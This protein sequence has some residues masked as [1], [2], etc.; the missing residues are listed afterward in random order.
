MEVGDEL[1]GISLPELEMSDR[2]RAGKGQIG[3]LSDFIREQL[4]AGQN[5]P[6]G[7]QTLQYTAEQLSILNNISS[8]KMNSQNIIFRIFIKPGGDIYLLI[9]IEGEELS[10]IITEVHLATAHSNSKSVSVLLEKKYYSTGLRNKVRDLLRQCIECVKYRSGGA[11]REKQTSLIATQPRKIL[12]VDLSGPWPP[13]NRARYIV[14]LVDAYSKMTYLRTVQTTSGSDMAD[15]LAKFFSANGL[16][17]ALMIDYKCLTLGGID[18]SLLKN[19]GI[20]ILRSNNL[21]RHQGI[22]ERKIRDTRLK[23]LKFLS[24]EPDIS[25]WAT[26]LPAVEFSLNATPSSVLGWQAPFDLVYRVSPSLL[27]PPVN[28][29]E[30]KTSFK[31]LVQQAED[32]RKAAYK[33]LVSRKSYFRPGEALA[34]GQLVWRKRHNFNRNMN[35]KLQARVLEAYEILDRVAT[36]LYRAKNVINNN[37]LVLPADHLIRCHLDLQQVKAII[38]KLGE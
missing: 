1:A 11:V 5:A 22:V 9:W 25:K 3:E 27:I 38:S 20:K 35:S 33:A 15:I 2:E 10:K 30:E 29:N 34:K 7:A 37:I 16:W 12:Q 26:T 24:Q 17:E 23:I 36:G 18:V 14:V 31:V 6:V 8:F 13:S 19:L 28:L 21:S 32:V 4:A